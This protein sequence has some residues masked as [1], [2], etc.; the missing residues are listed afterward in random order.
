MA[1]LAGLAV[2]LLAPGVAAAATQRGEP[3]NDPTLTPAVAQA[4]KE[5]TR[6]KDAEIASASAAARVAAPAGA[7]SL[8]TASAI[9]GLHTLNATNY[10]QET[11]Y[12]CGPASA[13]QSLSWHKA[14]S[15]SSA[16][17][18]SQRTLAG[19]IGTTTSGS[20]TTGI[21]RAMNS[22]NGVFGRVNYVASNL[23]DTGSPKS[24]FYNRI[25]WMLQDAR[26]VPVI[27]TQTRRIR[28]YEG[29]PSRHY[30]SVS[31]INDLSTPIK[32][33]SVDP[34]YNP[35]YRGVFWDEMGS[36]TSDGL[37]R[38]CYQADVDG[39]NMAMCW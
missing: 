18:P 26:T 33:R 2:A 25:G 28:R 31:G 38:A 6:K 12:Y 36:T 30:M 27:L 9:Y 19:R 15:G 14:R 37:C 17:L 4:W 16:S 21:V 20:L 24:A 29:H 23:T 22:Y 39:S 35:K 10:K 7:V 5:A 34:N 13:R 3:V 8:V 32:M 1:L 11:T